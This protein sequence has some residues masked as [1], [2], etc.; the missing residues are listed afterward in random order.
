MKKTLFKGSGV[1]IITP[2]TNGGADYDSFGRIIDFQIQNNTQAIIVCGTTG[3]SSVLSETEYESVIRFAI[4]KVNKRVPV[5][6]GTGSNNTAH[7]VK[8]SKFAQSAGADG[9]MAVTPYYNK[10][11]QDGLAAHY[12]AIADSVSLPVIVYNVPSRTG[13]NI[14]PETYA[15]LGKHENINAIKEANSNIGALAKTMALAGDS[16]NVYCGNDDEIVPFLSLGGVGVISVLANIAPKETQDICRLFFEGKTEESAK[17]QISMIELCGALFCE[18]N[19]IPVKY[20]MKLLG[21]G[22][23]EVRLPLIEMEDKKRLENAMRKA[24]LIS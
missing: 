23:G 4:E 9:L 13:M 22:N 5:I 19:P 21:Y 6:A 11:T 12:F 16:L 18:T 10:T 3:E 7:A 15:R 8:L 2:F 14:A 20:G 17:L 1:A 24:G